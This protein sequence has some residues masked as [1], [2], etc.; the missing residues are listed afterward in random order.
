MQESNR[1]VRTALILLSL[2]GLLYILGWMWDLVGRFAD[3]I[4]PFFLAWLLAFILYPLTDLLSRLSVPWPGKA[5]KVSH[6]AA[7]ILVYLGLI[8][9]LVILSVALVPIIIAQAAQ[10]GGSLPGYAAKLPSLAQL[11]SDLNAM[12]LPVD[13]NTQYQQQALL[14]QARQIGGTIAQNALGIAAG[15]ALM[16]FN[17]MIVLVLSFSFMLDGP[18]IS[19]SILE[20]VPPHYKTEATFFADSITRSFGG[21]I[22]GQLLQAAIYGAG[23]ALLMGVAGLPYIAAVGSFCALAMIIPFVGPIVALAPPLLLAAAQAPSSF[24][25]MLV[26]LVILQQVVTNVIAPKVMS[27]ALGLHPLL[28]LFATMIGVKVAG[29]WGALFGVPI[30]AVVYATAI[31]AYQHALADEAAEAH[32]HDWVQLR[33]IP[34]QPVDE[35]RTTE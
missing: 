5:R 30:V 13:L 2:I 25:W 8:L 28:V 23:T 27:Q 10:L 12:G 29:F 31:Y 17:V 4:L 19:K 18:R 1:W 33:T 20:I 16:A 24:P 32:R 15:I 22:R 6:T 26:A 14:D 21:F 35:I 3:I 7:A 34:E 11:Q 9:V